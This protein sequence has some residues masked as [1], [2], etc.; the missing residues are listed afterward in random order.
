MDILD[1]HY[2]DVTTAWLNYCDL[3]TLSPDPV[4]CPSPFGP[5]DIGDQW[6]QVFADNVTLETQDAADIVLLIDDS[7]SMNREHEWLVIMI[8]LLEQILISAG[9][10]LHSL[11]HSFRPPSYPVHWS[12]PMP[13]SPAGVGDGAV[14]NRYCAIAFGG[15]VEREQAHFLLVDGQPCFAA[16]D[17][18]RARALLK[19][20]GLR[21]DGYQA[22]RF[23]LD[24]VPFRQ[25]PL[26]AKNMILITDEG[27]TVIPQ[28]ADETRETIQVH[29]LSSGCLTVRSRETTDDNCYFHSSKAILSELCTK[30]MV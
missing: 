8:P 2:I 28:G 7:G 20:A 23:A 21:E 15:H 6:Y 18:P 29:G 13:P 5:Q 11:A 27:R 10:S 17:F 3:C 22:I 9:P 12:L 14:R 25:S 16:A 4:Q 30:T 26:I 19:N 1:F 24:N